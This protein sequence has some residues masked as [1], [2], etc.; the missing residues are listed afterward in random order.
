MTRATGVLAR[1]RAP[2]EVRARV[3]CWIHGGEGKE[4]STEEEDGH[5]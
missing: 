2:I 4:V 3:P 5:L 1:A